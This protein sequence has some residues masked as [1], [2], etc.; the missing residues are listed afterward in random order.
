M[1]N[2]E[3]FKFIVNDSMKKKIDETIKYCMAPRRRCDQNIDN[4]IEK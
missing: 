1:Y 4:I 2:F 3:L